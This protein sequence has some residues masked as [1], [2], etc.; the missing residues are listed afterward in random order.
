MTSEL[1]LKVIEIMINCS[2]IVQSIEYLSLKKHFS[3]KGIWRWSEIKQEHPVLPI[4]SFLLSENNFIY[5][6]VA[7]I[8]SALGLIFFFPHSFI[9]ILFLFFTSLLISLRFRGS[10][11]GGSDYM[12]L[13]I[14]SALCIAAFF[15]TPRVQMGVLWYISLQ[16]CTSYFIAGMVKIKQRKWRNAEALSKHMTSSNYNPPRWSQNIFSKK[17]WAM[18][19]AWG[20]IVFEICFPIILTQHNPSVLYWLLA[21][22]LFHLTNV[23]FFGLNRFLIVWCATYPALYFIT[24]N[25]SYSP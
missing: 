13:I 4:F 14:L 24:N 15:K 5:F 16:V 11:N 25:F 9:L 17:I 3:E 2:I 23:L 18:C 1:A 6:L 22:F 10:F 20:V 19:A 8:V 7:R 12:A 21:G